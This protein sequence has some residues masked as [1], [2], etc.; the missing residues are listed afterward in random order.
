MH[1]KLSQYYENKA[2]RHYTRVVAFAVLGAFI[3]AYLT[4]YVLPTTTTVTQVPE[5]NIT[6]SSS[7]DVLEE[8]TPLLLR[9]PAIKLEVPFGKPLGLN[10]DQT[11]EVPEGYE[12]VGYYKFGPTPGE[13]GPAVVLGHVDSYQGP[14]VF[15]ELG[16]LE[17]GDEIY[18]DRDD[19][20]TAVFVVD[21]LESHEQRGFPTAKV[22]SDIDYAGL[23]LITCTGVYN[24]GTQE[25]S[26]NLIVFAKLKTDD[27]E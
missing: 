26:H 10:A 7:A 6:A 16:Q 13:L 22:Y 17:A 14:A 4:S 25:Y 9:I 3:G 8:A 2:V 20:T 15:F 24:H 19:G 5:I 27:S 18:V 21:H 12:E 1:N 11:V 23:R